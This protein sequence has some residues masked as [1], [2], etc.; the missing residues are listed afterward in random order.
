MKTTTLSLL[1]LALTLMPLFA[2]AQGISTAVMEVRVEVVSGS[3]VERSDSGQLITFSD[4]TDEVLYGDFYL[5]LPE[6]VQV[7][8]SASDMLSLA[9]GSDNMTLDST[10]NQ[11]LDGNGGLRLQFTAK[12]ST[13][14]KAGTYSGTQVAEIFYL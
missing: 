9:N 11:S 13:A 10:V 6:D 7:I 4:E 5:T 14:S 2:A 1:T 8:T 3:S 12:N